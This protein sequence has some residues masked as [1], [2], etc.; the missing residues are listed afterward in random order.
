[1]SATKKFWR[2]SEMIAAGKT[3]KQI[4]A[5]MKSGVI[6]RLA[7][8]LYSNEEP[9]DLLILEGLAW[10]NPDLIY[11]GRTAA[12]LHGMC[13]MAWPAQASV[14]RTCSGDG[15]QRL[16]LSTATTGPV[17]NVR[18]MRAVSPIEAGTGAQGIDRDVLRRGLQRAY[19]GPKAN[20]RLARHLADLPPRRR[21]SAAKLLDGVPTGIASGLEAKAVRGIVA[22]LD[23]LDVTVLINEMVR[24]YR[25][26]LVIPEANVCIEID[27]R[28]YH[29]TGRASDR[30]FLNDRWKANTAVRWGWTLLR[31]SDIDINEAMSFVKEQVRD[32]VEF[33]LANSRSRKLREEEIPTDQQWWLWHPWYR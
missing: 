23:G 16:E 5:A 25:F 27:S 7:H 11:T 22:A 15:G 26:D 17:V 31:Y 3:Y 6:H 20:D 18:G 2:T 33:N 28:T 19:L 24:G 13:D 32:T 10:A 12:F 21:A 4:T 30:A 29:A 1:M 14:P 9:S 8:G